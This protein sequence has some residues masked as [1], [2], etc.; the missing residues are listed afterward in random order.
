MNIL[1]SVDDKY[2]EIAKVMLFSIKS[3]VKEKISVYALYQGASKAFE[4]F[5][6]FVNSLGGVEVY[7]LDVPEDFAQGYKVN[8][9]YSIAMYFRIFAHVLVP[10]NIDRIL[11]LDADIIVNKDIKEFY[12]S[13]FGDK[14]MI[15]NE[16]KNA[17]TEGVSKHKEELGISQKHKYFNSGVLLMNLK[18]MREDITQEYLTSTIE[19]L[20]D[21][22]WYPDQDVLNKVYENK[23]KYDDHN[24]YNAQYFYGN[25]PS[26]PQ[27]KNA[28]II[29]FVGGIKPWCYNGI[30]SSF[31]KYFWIYKCKMNKNYVAE[32]A[33]TYLLGIVYKICRKA[34]RIV[35]NCVGT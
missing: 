24:K 6:Q 13:D 5:E 33:Y 22:L 12:D 10:E 32:Y 30:I 29:H 7:K 35:K 19:D 16:D 18:K 8:L 34:K 4:S 31:S 3:N 20:Q 23:V 1:I 17:E 14:Y 11:Y 9:H 28:H 26:G 2:L 21:V 25:H 27:L 15:V